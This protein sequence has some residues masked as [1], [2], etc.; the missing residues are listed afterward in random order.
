MFCFKQLFHDQSNI[1]YY[2]YVYPLLDNKSVSQWEANSLSD[3]SRCLNVYLHFITFEM[4]TLLLKGF[5]ISYT[6]NCSWEINIYRLWNDILVY[7]VLTK[8]RVPLQLTSL[9]DDHLLYLTVQIF[10]N[11]FHF[12]PMFSHT[13]RF[14]S[15]Q[16]PC[17]SNVE[18]KSNFWNW[19]Y[20]VPRYAGKVEGNVKLNMSDVTNDCSLQ[21]RVKY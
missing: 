11:K 3:Y 9:L 18:Y 5:Y 7:A 16:V 20:T 10:H 12:L 17:T 19:G 13:S 8:K 1:V 14:I 21:H 15:L 2:Y 6:I 4:K